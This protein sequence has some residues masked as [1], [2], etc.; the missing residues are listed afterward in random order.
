MIFSSPYNQTPTE[1]FFFLAFA[2][3]E[4]STPEHM[5]TKYFHV[6]AATSC[7]NDS[8]VKGEQQEGHM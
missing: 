1:L 4:N 3:I 7:L 8:I 6:I 2:D 5:K